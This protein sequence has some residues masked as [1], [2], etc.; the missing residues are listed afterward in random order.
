MPS[1]TV[2][3]ASGSAVTVP[4]TTS[5]NIALAQQ[6]AARISQAVTDGTDIPSQDVVI[7]LPPGKFGEFVKTQSGMN[8]LPPGYRDVVNI[9]ANAIIFGSGDA[10]EQILSGTG[11]LTFFA[12]AGSGTLVAGG[13][14]NSIYI[15]A[16][17]SG[18][19]DIAT[20]V[21]HNQ[22]SDL[23]TGLSSISA[24]GGN[25]SLQ[26]GSGQYA[27]NS[28]GN[29]TI[30]A[31]AGAETVGVT[32]GASDLVLGFSSRL[33]F[34]NGEGSST[35]LGG[36]GSDTVFAGAG[37]GQFT[38]G[39]AGNNLL[40]GGAGAATLFGAGNNDVLNAAGSNAQALHAGPGNET[41]FGA[42]GSGADTFYA[43]AGATTI[44]TGTGN[45]TIAFI[46][47]QAGGIDVVNNFDLLPGTDKI[48]LQGYG[49]N[50]AANAIAGQI[51]GPTGTVLTFSDGTKVTFTGVNH[52]DSSNFS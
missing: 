29:D 20:D 15:G 23:S 34:I 13:G 22:I 42:L 3:G 27:V 25:N 36:T 40:N 49:P 50:E 26:L 47:G 30:I 52:I 32:G 17:D 21:G 35:V 44:T 37:G 11:N 12:A 8:M 45:D 19:W 33:D 48:G 51:A 7:P 4:F 41:L 31:G 10:N 28:T 1:V 2:L 43:S 24:G 39:T 18:N 46:N 38:G 14:N 16:T 6:V 5:Q 9:S